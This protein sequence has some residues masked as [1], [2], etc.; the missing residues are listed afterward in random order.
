MSGTATNQYTCVRY[1]KEKIARHENG[2]AGRCVEV[3]ESGRRRESGGDGRGRER[4]RCT[5]RP[6]VSGKIKH[7]LRL[8]TGGGT[9]PEKQDRNDCTVR[10]KIWW[11]GEFG[12][13]MDGG[14]G[15]G[16]DEASKHQGKRDGH[17]WMLKCV[18]RRGILGSSR[19]YWYSLGPPLSAGSRGARYH[20]HY[21]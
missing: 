13:E 1:N 12:C 15:T 17:G 6:G 3:V 19:W 18:W 5:I 16:E 10:A 9:M 20:S 11:P 21:M 7:V 14:E 2:D 8:V 4:T